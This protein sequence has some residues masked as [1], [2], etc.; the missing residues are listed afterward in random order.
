MPVYRAQAL[1]EFNELKCSC[2]IDTRFL[3]DDARFEFRDEKI[4][5]HRDSFDFW[6]WSRQALGLPG[7]LLGWSPYLRAKVARTAAKSLERFAAGS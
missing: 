5:R 3:Y 2:R 6:K 4:I 7:L 1:C